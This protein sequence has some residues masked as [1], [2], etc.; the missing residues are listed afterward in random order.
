[1]SSGYRVISVAL[2]TC[3]VT[4]TRSAGRTT[5]TTTARLRLP[6][7]LPS[8]VA[9]TDRMR[10]PS[11]PVDCVQPAATSLAQVSSPV[12]RR[13]ATTIVP[14]RPAAVT[15]WIAPNSPL[16]ESWKRR[17]PLS[18]A[19]GAARCSAS[20]DI[21]ARRASTVFGVADDGRPT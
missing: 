14:G 6:L 4:M 8:P 21:A 17:S 10:S 7:L 2:S 11:G 16:N 18:F 15:S 9:G 12:A 3:T 1:M 13:A 20:R 19:S 5:S